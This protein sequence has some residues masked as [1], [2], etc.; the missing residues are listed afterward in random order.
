[1]FDTKSTNRQQISRRRVLI[2]KSKRTNRRKTPPL[3][4]SSWIIRQYVPLD[5]WVRMR[6][7]SVR[8]VQVFTSSLMVPKI[9]QQ[10]FTTYLSFTWETNLMTTGNWEQRRSTVTLSDLEVDF[11]FVSLLFQPLSIYITITLVR[12][13][14][15]RDFYQR[16]YKR[17]IFSKHLSTTKNINLLL[18]ISL[19]KINQS[20]SSPL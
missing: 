6:I 2:V 12:V 9:Y 15:T 11:I 13:D 7:T 1:M 10:P 3:Y 20:P 5:T 17:K 8:F 18:I 14:W 16:S 4:Y 19:R